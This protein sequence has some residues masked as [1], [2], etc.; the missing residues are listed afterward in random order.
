MSHSSGS[1]RADV[2]II[3]AG[4]AGLACARRLHEA[5]VSVAIY[6][7]G[8]GPGGR[9]S[10]RR[11]PVGRFDHGAQF[12]TIRDEGF[13]RACE[14]WRTEGLIARWD[15]DHRKNGAPF[16]HDPWHVG[17]PKMAAFVAHEAEALGAGFGYRLAAP[18]REGGRWHL[19]TEG[20]E[21]AWAADWVV[22]AVPAEQAAVLLPPE[23]PLRAQAAAARSAPTWTLM[24]A[25][26]DAPAPFDTDQPG[27]GPLAFLSR[28]ASRPGAEPGGRWVAHA[29]SD[30]TRAH[31]E[32]AP[33]DVARILA[34]ALGDALGARGAPRH[35]AAHRW[36]YAQVETAAPASYGL[37]ADARLATCGD[38]HVAPRV[39]S[40]WVSGDALG[41]ALLG[42]L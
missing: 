12:F 31:L 34:A 38:W 28:Q 15:G 20:G 19:Y 24:A 35:C 42:Q 40:A 36:R 33:E 1:E 25:W 37:D 2:A 4:V 14:A 11:T 21:S 6:D 16:S 8:R 7:K 18:R 32:E 26:D 5:G 29:T 23:T 39:E 27:E 3:G 17:T 22:L 9:L 13:A 41:R 10:G 30:W